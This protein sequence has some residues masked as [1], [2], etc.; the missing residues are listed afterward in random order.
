MEYLSPDAPLSLTL[1]LRHRLPVR[2]R[3]GSAIDL[4]E[5]TRRVTKPVEG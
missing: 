3:P 1:Y 4:S 2:R 5:L